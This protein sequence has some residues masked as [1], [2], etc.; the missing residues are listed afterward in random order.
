[1]MLS[2]ALA[3]LLLLGVLTYLFQWKA[4][5]AQ[6]GITIIYIISGFLGGVWSRANTLAYGIIQASVYMVVLLGAS[7]LVSENESWDI[8]QILL[9]W[10]LT[11]GSCVLGIKV[12]SCR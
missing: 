11:S 5:Q 6:L 9:R 1:M 12:F 3:M 7:L 2:A 8:V 4:A 10:I